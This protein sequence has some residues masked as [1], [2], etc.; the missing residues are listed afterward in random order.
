MIPGHFTTIDD[1]APSEVSLSQPSASQESTSS[2]RN[3]NS[4]KIMVRSISIYIVTSSGLRHESQLSPPENICIQTIT[5]GYTDEAD[6]ILN[7]LV[8]AP[9]S[10]RLSAKLSHF[11]S[12]IWDI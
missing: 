6:K 5:R 7:Y 10:L 12:G 9:F 1:Y 2:R 4:F 8:Y 3:V 11:T